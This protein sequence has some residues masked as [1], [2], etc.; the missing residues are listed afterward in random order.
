MITFDDSQWPLLSVTFTGTLS[1]QEF[2]DYLSKMTASL[3][4]GEKYLSLLDTRG[5]SSAP[6]MEQ[7][8]LLVAWVR[9]NE[10]ALRQLLL[11]SAFVI[12]SPFI[13]L[14][15][16]IMCQLKPMPSPYTIVGDLKVARAWTAERFR[17]GG[18]VPPASLLEPQGAAST[19]TWGRR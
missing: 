16:N 7:R 12:T 9:R 8:Q 6:G 19:G 15:M 14:A 3:S 17:A 2:D 5:L 18:L 10:P 4:R 13:R 1:A 11:G